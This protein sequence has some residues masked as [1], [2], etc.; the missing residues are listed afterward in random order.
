MG[1]DATNIMATPRASLRPNVQMKTSLSA[2]FAVGTLAV[3]AAAACLALDLVFPEPSFLLQTSAKTGP[4]HMES[5]AECLGRGASPGWWR[6]TYG[7][8][9]KPQN[10]SD[11]KA[12]WGEAPQW[13]ASI[14]KELLLDKSSERIP[15]SAPIAPVKQDR[16]Q[17]KHKSSDTLRFGKLSVPRTNTNDFMTATEL[18]PNVLTTT[19]KVLADKPFDISGTLKRDKIQVACVGDSLT[20]GV[21][22]S[23]PRKMSYPAKLQSK[24]GSKYAVTNLGIHQRSLQTGSFESSWGQNV[25]YTSSNQYKSL[26]ENEWDLIVVM[27]GTNDADVRPE[28]FDI[29]L[30][31]KDYSKL[32]TTFKGL[33]RNG[34]PPR[35]FLLAPPPFARCVTR[36]N[37]TSGGA[38]RQPFIINDLF[39]KMLPDIAKGNDVQ[40]ID[41][42]HELGGVDNWSQTYPYD[43]QN[44]WTA[45]ICSTYCVKSK[46]FGVH[47]ND[48]GYEDLA[49]VVATQIAYHHGAVAG[50]I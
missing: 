21:G 23:N 6:A 7:A 29:R 17:S 39:P 50:Q 38:K 16:R 49:T 5:T 18:P 34:K 36:M 9:P 12:V 10:L 13:N 32:L 8:I 31:V 11:Y 22:S 48:K 40:F 4:P 19:E 44:E 2:V 47:L 20:Q 35:I 25:P 42:F 14:F 1:H 30:F 3:V 33:G 37:P 15:T 28:K 43:C 27:L 26:V 41:M 45:P 24:L 46:C